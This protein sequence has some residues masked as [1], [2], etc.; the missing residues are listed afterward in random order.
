MGGSAQIT[1]PQS[2]QRILLEPRGSSRLSSQTLVDLRLSR[3]IS[4]GGSTRVELLVD[5]LNAFNDTAEEGL[6]TDTV[7]SDIRAVG[8]FHRSTPRNDWREV[9]PWPVTEFEHGSAFGG[10]TMVPPGR[11]LLMTQQSP[12]SLAEPHPT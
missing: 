9:E 1:L 11:T 4:L 8:Q 6:V 12:I 7:Q 5:V 3:A 2:D 10:P